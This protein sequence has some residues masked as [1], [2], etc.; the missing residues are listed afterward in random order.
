MAQND[1]I[2]PLGKLPPDF[3]KAIFSKAPAHDPRVILGPG[4]GLDCAVLDL[5]AVLLVFKNE[6]ITFV[7]DQIG[8][9]AIQIAANDI[10]TT[11]AQ[12]RWYLATLLLP[13]GKTTPDLV[14]SITEQAYAACRQLGISIIGGHTEVTHGLDRPILAGTLIGEVSR[15]RLITPKGCQPG[16]RILLT[17]G[18]PI[19]GT[20][21]LAR[22]FPERL[23]EAL[24]PAE[25]EQAKN[26]LYEPG[27]SVVRDAQI[28]TQVG[29]ITA[30]HD[31]TEGGLAA[32][33]WE[34][35]QASGHTFMIEM[36]KVVIPSLS[37]RICQVFGLDP[38]ATIASG[39]LLMTAPAVGNNISDILTALHSAGIACAEIGWVE[40]SSEDGAAVVQVQAGPAPSASR[41]GPSSLFQKPAASNRR[42]LPWPQRDEITKAYE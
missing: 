9:Y 4:I 13:E 41:N 1:T 11:G 39:A 28:A 37:A 32:A 19:E 21:I 31:P 26:Y 5:G 35:A 40:T 29:K 10:V 25:I 7:T 15:D 8:W 12:P 22:E 20:A 16:D 23:K 2:F 18:V 14:E 38:L 6:P 27:I 3:L 36:D 42:V 34:M 24:S 17:K 33:L 30:M